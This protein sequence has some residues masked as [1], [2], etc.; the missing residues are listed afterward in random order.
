MVFLVFDKSHCNHS[1]KI[2]KRKCSLNHLLT[3]SKKSSSPI[4][5]GQAFKCFLFRQR[6][7]DK[8]IRL[9]VTSSNRFEWRVPSNLAKNYHQTSFQF[10]VLVRSCQ[11]YWCYCFGW[12]IVLYC[13]CARSLWLFLILVGLFYCASISS[14]C[15]GTIFSPVF[16]STLNSQQLRIFSVQINIYSV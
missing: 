4:W 14:V 15:F 9:Q 6:K 8:V 7:V 16:Q 2:S 13:C 10:E 3:Q 5:R 12:K 11:N 1:I